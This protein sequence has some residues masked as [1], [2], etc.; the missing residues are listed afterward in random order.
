MKRLFVS[1]VLMLLTPFLVGSAAASIC[2]DCHSG[3]TP[4]IVEDFQSGVMGMS[5]GIDYC[6]LHALEKEGV[7][8][9]FSY[10]LEF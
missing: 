8:D 9:P 7:G 4:E 1:L 2:I 10:F 6:T 5:E 3:I